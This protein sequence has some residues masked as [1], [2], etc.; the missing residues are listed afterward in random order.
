MV[1]KENFVVVIKCNGMIL[2]EKDGYTTLPFGSEY[3]ILLKNLDSRKA[4]VNIDIDGNDVL[5]GDQLVINPNESTELE[6]FKKDNNVKSKF[7]FIQ[8]TDEIIEYRGDRIDDGMI[9]VEVTFEK[10]VEEIKYNWTYTYPYTYP[11]TDLNW[12]YHT[13][14][15]RSCINDNVTLY[16]MSCENVSNT[17][18]NTSFNLNNDEGITV[19]GSDSNQKF[20]SVSTEELENTSTVIIL[21]LRGVDREKKEVKKPITVRDKLECSTCGR[22]S[23]SNAKFCNNC[24]TRL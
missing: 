1:Y 14:I 19:E 2:R 23:K 4:V 11:Y 16:N 21:K 22:K 10:K 5:D 24:G 15:M 12:W 8:K 9:R 13:P 18:N 3:S 7:K 6:G 17:L 20:I